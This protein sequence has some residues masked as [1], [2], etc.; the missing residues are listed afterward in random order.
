[1]ANNVE[2]LL[3]NVI[4]IQVCIFAFSSMSD[5]VLLNNQSSEAQENSLDTLGMS[6]FLSIIN[7]NSK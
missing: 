5:F 3:L 2:K 6:I 7:L 1:M 4:F